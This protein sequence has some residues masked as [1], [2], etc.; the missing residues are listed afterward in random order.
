MAST[1]RE[2][3]RLMKAAFAPATHLAYENGIKVFERFRSEL[4]LPQT[5]PVKQEHVPHFVAYLSLQN[6]SLATTK[7]YLAALAAKH[8]SNGWPDYTDTWIIKKLLK[9]FGKKLSSKDCKKP[10]TLEKLNEILRIL[11]FVCSNTFEAHLLKAAFT[12]A[13]YGFFRVSELLGQKSNIQGGRPPLEHQD[14]KL[15]AS[16][17]K[18]WLRMSKTDQHGQG[19]T[20]LIQKEVSEFCPLSV[21]GNYLRERGSAQGPLLVHKNGKP[22]TIYQF[23]GVLSKAV[24][25][26]KWD[27]KGF[28]PHSFRIGAATTAAINKMSEDEIMAKGRWKSCAYKRYIRQDMV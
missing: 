25:F 9:G 12:L 8:K 26:L 22:L 7:T 10:I 16:H 3:G 23:Q 11:P 21:M 13:F 6:K 14:I 17:M 5:W 24:R 4:A 15:Y 2:I 28:V 20:V 1:E 18:V 27:P 19:A